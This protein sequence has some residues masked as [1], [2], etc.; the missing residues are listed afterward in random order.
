[1]TTKQ[2]RITSD[3]LNPLYKMS[4]GFDRLADDF[5]TDPAFTN[6]SASGYPP[7]NINKITK[8]DTEEVDYEIV[9]ALAGFTEKDI[10]LVVENG[11]LKISGKSGCLNETDATDEEEVEYLH[12]GIAERSFTRTFKLAEY[13]EVKSASL[14]NGI[15]RVR[16]WRNIPEAAKPKLIA[17]TS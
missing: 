2:Y 13:V 12:K 16:L 11:S 3:L 10:E 17:I 8:T 4:V 15:L 14:R 1:M 5:L 7:F 6:A 9:L